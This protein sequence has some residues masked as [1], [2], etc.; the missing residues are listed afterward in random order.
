M[1]SF[2][3]G[4]ESPNSFDRRPNIRTMRARMTSPARKLRDIDI[5]WSSSWSPFVNLIGAASKGTSQRRLGHANSYSETSRTRGYA[6]PAFQ[7]D[8][9]SAKAVPFKTAEA[10]AGASDRTDTGVKDRGVTCSNDI[11]NS[12]RVTGSVGGNG[13]SIR[14][15]LAIPTLAERRTLSGEPTPSPSPI[16]P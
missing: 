8:S 12:I 5:W 9:Q 14:I 16:P 1:R 6:C 13:A 15:S 4:P 2:A 11:L 7:W 3:D 10:A